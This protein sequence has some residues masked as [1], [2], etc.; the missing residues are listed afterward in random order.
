MNISNFTY[1][2]ANPQNLTSE[3]LAALDLLIRKYPYFQ[4]ARALQL[5][6]LKNQDSFLYNDALK[7][8]AAHTT[9]RDILF[10]YITSEK[11]IQN[12]I[13]QT[14]L[15]HD[16]SVNEINVVSEN[17]ND[18]VKEENERLLKAE[19]KKAEDILNPKLFQRKA[20]DVT[21]TPQEKEESPENILK[22]DKPLEFT[23]SDT[24]SFSEWL[25]LTKA[26]PIERKE[27]SKD[28]HSENAKED[29]SLIESN[30]EGTFNQE[31]KERKFQLIEKFIQERPKIIPS[32][33]S[34][35]SSQSGTSIPDNPSNK[36][37]LTDF[38]QSSDSL[39]TETL[40]KVYLQQKNYK[41]AIQAYKIL[42]LKNPE[43][44]GFF[45]DQ[46]RAIEKLTNTE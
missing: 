23:K 33:D 22:T 9:D 12:E 43:K 16:D 11:F 37:L 34:D 10:E 15:Q 13:S 31:E 45:A 27:A 7:L 8:T 40:A 25:K 21:E 3:D 19:I 32:A 30:N 4:S 41:K 6:G 35:K 36:A 26:K 1:L 18:E 46:I 5:K 38:T 39:M 17:I 44:S 29:D 42:I 14:I 2:L 24:H 20:Q 28:L